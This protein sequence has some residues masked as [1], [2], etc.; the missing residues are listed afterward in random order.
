MSQILS[1]DY[2]SVRL[3][4]IMKEKQTFE[5]T[6]ITF[7]K[8]DRVSHNK[9]LHGKP[10]SDCGAFAK[11]AQKTLR[12]CECNGIAQSP[13]EMK[14][15]REASSQFSHKASDI[16]L[17]LSL[18]GSKTANWFHRTLLL[19]TWSLTRNEKP[20]AETWWRPYLLNHCNHRAFSTSQH[21]TLHLEDSGKL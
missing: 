19:H 14:S 12:E 2:K 5:D 20:K 7:I 8:G 4:V 17:L 3:W 1:E 10:T 18:D 13:R 15:R 21:Q 11:R 16:P 6:K 9:R